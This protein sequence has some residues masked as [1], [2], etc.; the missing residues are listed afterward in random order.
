MR[1]SHH[2]RRVPAF[3]PLAVAAA[4]WLL[5]GP[6]QAQFYAYTGSVSAVPADVN[7]P[8]FNVGAVL[9]LGNSAAGSFS[10]LAGALLSADGLSIANGG[11]GNGSMLVTGTGTVANLVG[12]THRVEV[13]NWGVGSL[14]VSGG[15][16]LDGTANAGVCTDCY[17]YIGHGAGSTA[18]LTV[19]GVNSEMRLLRNVT[20]GT[21]A[22]HPGLGTPGGTTNA[23]VNVLAGGTLRTQSANVGVGPGGSTPTG[24]EQ[25]VANVL[26]NGANS[27]WIVSPNTID[28]TAAGLTLANHVNATATVLVSGGGQLRVDGSGGPGP[29]D[30]MNIGVNG[31]RATVTVTGVGSSVDVV[32]V[33]SVLQVGRSGP[34]PVNPS[35]YNGSF[36]VLAGATASTL[37]LNVARD[38]ARGRMLI[39]GAGSKLSQVGVGS[40]QSPGFNGPAYTYIG[41][42]GGQGEVTVSGGGE[43]LMSQ[44][45]G[46]DGRVSGNGM[47]IGLGRGVNSSGSLLITGAGSKV[48]IVS[49][50]MS[51]GAGVGDNRN[52]SVD[53]GYDNPGTSSGTLSIEAGGKLILTGNAVSTLAN[54]RTTALNIGGRS[55][56]AATGT[57]TVTGANSEIIVQGND[58]YIGVGREAGSTGT[59]NVLADGKVSSTS[60]AIGISGTGTVN[61]DDATVALSGFRTNTNPV[62]GAGMTVGR[63]AGSNAALNMSNGATL[64]ITPT[65]YTSGFAVGGDSFLSGGTGAVTM[66]GGSSIVVGGPLIGNGGTVGR[67]GTGTVTMSQASFIEMGTGATIDFGRSP[68]GVGN[69]SL[70]SGSW[71]RANQI[72]F[73]GINDVDP[74]GIATSTV[75][76]SGSRLQAEGAIGRL[77]VGRGGTGTLTVSDEAKLMATFLNVGRAPTGTGT[78]TANNAT[79]DVS[80]QKNLGGTEFGASFGVGTRGGVGTAALANN[81]QVTIKNETLAGNVGAFLTVG[82]NEDAPLSGTGV[83][84]VSGGSSIT[85]EA[86][87]GPAQARIGYSGIGT[88]AFSGGSSLNV[89]NGDVYVGQ[90]AGSVGV[91]TLGGGSTINAAYIGVGVS[92]P[93]S[94]GVQTN[95]G[96][97][98]IVLNDSTINAGMFELGAGGVLTGNN[99][100][101]NVVGDVVIGGV[102]APGNSPGRLRI[103]C[104][105]ITLP[106]S[107]IILEVSGSGSSYSID[108]L[109]IGSEASFDL[110]SAQIVFSFIGATDPNA[111]AATGNFN[112]DNFLRSA[113]GNVEA[114]LSTAFAPGQSWD[115]VVNTSQIMATSE[116]YEITSFSFDGET[117]GVAITATPVPEPSTWAMLVF[118]LAGLGALA[119]R[120]QAAGG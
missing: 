60:L 29:N 64:T 35:F 11:I 4:V 102:I 118:G 76:G 97:G 106:G 3:Q 58:A 39:D 96:T 100:V 2:A 44:G 98:V 82:G 103:N 28:N 78:L 14:T 30:F 80:G 27:R 15:A 12:N 55:G 5:T 16:L 57:A 113:T 116:A 119:R 37:Y 89:V 17:S 62:T 21:T 49:T 112:L 72:Q 109:I 95:G 85:I 9:S 34:A 24:T 66:S 26:I 20:I 68:G 108:E 115:N 38:G 52:P 19:T 90:Q 88:A 117:G 46:G 74:G 86:T 36:E 101:L 40:N 94:G 63:G 22:V 79:I 65:T 56:T 105:I 83:L 59:L 54:G 32:G 92:Q 8:I 107:Q 77:S 111:F 70:S 7:N 41:R 69:L 75:S 120:R 43:W 53:V 23:T 84:S 67:T 91:L 10:A 50:S 25:S 6:A 61:I 42:E 104:N 33:N 18:T 48:E 31:G 1:L 51:P 45:V 13:G 110:A 99:G 87:G 81:T 71:L 73:G 93:Y 114:G 47:G